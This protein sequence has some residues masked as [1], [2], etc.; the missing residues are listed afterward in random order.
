MNTSP[1]L[2]VAEQPEPSQQA[3]LLAAE[4]VLASLCGRASRRISQVSLPDNQVLYALPTDSWAMR[5]NRPLLEDVLMTLLASQAAAKIL[6]L[7]DNTVT[8]STMPLARGTLLGS[9]TE[10]EE[11]A[12]A[13]AYLQVLEARTRAALRRY[14]TE[15]QVVAAGLREHGILDAEDVRHRIHCAQSIRSTLL[16]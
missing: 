12:V 1:S 3:V 2:H 9:L 7:P 5:H 15:V 11:V 14:W 8:A 10:P 6:E 13:E 16:N 4:A